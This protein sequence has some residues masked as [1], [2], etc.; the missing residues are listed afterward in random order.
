MG[1]L[2]DW[3]NFRSHLHESIDEAFIVWLVDNAQCIDLRNSASYLMGEHEWNFQNML[4]YIEANPHI[5]TDQINE[6]V[7][8]VW[9][10][11]FADD[12]ADAPDFTEIDAS[13]IGAMEV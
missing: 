10:L 2:T 4:D 1:I 11:C 8:E 7:H 3:F 5:M 9:M 13:W 6:A 12:M